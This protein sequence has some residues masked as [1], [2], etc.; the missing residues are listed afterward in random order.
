[1]RTEIGALDN[2]SADAFWIGMAHDWDYLHG[3][4]FRRTVSRFTFLGRPVDLD[5]LRERHQRSCSV[6]VIAERYG[7]N[8]SVVIWK[9]LC[10]V[11]WRMPSTNTS[12]VA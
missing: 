7:A 12:V 11:A 9:G 1:M 5:Q 4:N 2:R 10:S 3:L 6:L 8:P